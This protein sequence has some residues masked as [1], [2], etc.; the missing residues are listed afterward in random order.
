MDGMTWFL[1]ICSTTM[2]G[3]PYGAGHPLP[4]E[5]LGTNG[6]KEAFG[7]RWEDSAARVNDVCH[8]ALNTASAA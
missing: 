8:K 2:A 4:P 5:A 1:L 3:L 6:R 7:F